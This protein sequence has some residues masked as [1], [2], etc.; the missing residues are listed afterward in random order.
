MLGIMML[1]ERGEWWVV[2]YASVFAG[3]PVKGVLG[4][5]GCRAGG[6]RGLKGCADVGVGM[7]PCCRR[8]SNIQSLKKNAKSAVSPGAVD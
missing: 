8:L 1:K 4:K 5:P 7:L 2:M 3:R 6:L